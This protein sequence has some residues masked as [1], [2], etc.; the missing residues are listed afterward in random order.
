MIYVRSL[1]FDQLEIP[2]H[3]LINTQRLPHTIV[4]EGGDAARR[5][6]LAR[7][8]ALCAVCGGEE[9]PC[10]ACPS[11]VRAMNSNH[12]DVFTY[13]A[14]GAPRAFPV[15]VVR[16][17]RRDC[18]IRPNNGRGKVYILENVQSM[19]A[20]P[21]NALLKILEEPPAYA[22]FVLTCPSASA[23]LATV[24]SRSVVLTVQSEET[25]GDEYAPYIASIARALLGRTE[26]ELLFLVAEMEKDKE[27]LLPVLDGLKACFHGAMVAK[28]ASLPDGDETQSLL[29]SRLTTRQLVDLC[30]VCDETR[31]GK[32][33]NA[34]NSL[35][36][37]D[38]CAKMRM[39]AGF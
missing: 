25:G 20:P 10:M 19:D 16:Q 36:L 2:F 39:S 38:F 4:V 18:F 23:L 24:L 13:T 31:Q 6:A 11:C 29:R 37:T 21:Q 27:R 17:V 3:G 12:P 34:N 5:S 15:D 9:P 28:T 1:S 7:F 32:A 30:R 8:L 14:S 33:R 26:T 35:L 22:L